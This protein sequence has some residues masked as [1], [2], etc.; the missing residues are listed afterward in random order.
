MRFSLRLALRLL[1]CTLPFWAAAVQAADAPFAGELLG[2]CN[3]ADREMPF[4][5]DPDIGQHRQ[6]GQEHGQ[7]ARR[8][9][10]AA[11]LGAD[12]LTA[13]E[14]GARV[15]GFDRSLDFL[16]GGG[17]IL[18]AAGLALG[19]N[20]QVSGFA[21]FLD[22]DFAQAQPVERRPYLLQRDR[23][24]Q[25]DLDLDAALEVDAVIEAGRKEQRE[26]G[27][28]QDRRQGDTQEACAHEGDGGAVRNDPGRQQRRDADAGQPPPP[29]DRGHR[30]AHHRD[31]GEQ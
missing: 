1:V 24:R 17:L 10:L 31:G 7:G 14:D 22:R 11:D 3:G 20:E 21:E 25:G 6:A 5:T 23:R 19:A 4:E 27:Q 28:R 12:D 18:L 16:E 13:L 2:G 30:H 29:D 8:G 15:E 26:R 9:Q